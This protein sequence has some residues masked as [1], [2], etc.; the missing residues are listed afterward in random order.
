MGQWFRFCTRDLFWLMICTSLVLGW[1]VSQDR[2]ARHGPRIHLKSGYSPSGLLGEEKPNSHSLQ[3][4]V[5]LDAWGGGSGMLTVDS[6]YLFHDEFGT[7]RMG[8]LVACGARPVTLAQ[9]ARKNPGDDDGSR[10]YEIVGHRQPGRLFLVVPRYR[11]SA[12]RLIC[13]NTVKGRHVVV[14]DS[15][16]LH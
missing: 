7:V 14:L 15:G 4:Q 12:C 13:E 8:T 5:Q 6:N 10:C 2:Q 3:L 11:T 16:E 1:V 9:V